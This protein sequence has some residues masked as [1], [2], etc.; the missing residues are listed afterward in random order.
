MIFKR[1]LYRQAKVKRKKKIK[2]KL[3]KQKLL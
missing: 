1:F 2:K 3:T